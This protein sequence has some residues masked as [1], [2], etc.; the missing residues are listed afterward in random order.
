[1]S[2]RE[3]R[4]RG[5]RRETEEHFLRLLLLPRRRS[6][7][8][9]SSTRGDKC[10]QLPT[11]AI[12][13][14]PFLPV[15]GG[16]GDGGGEEGEGG[17]RVWCGLGPLGARVVGVG[18]RGGAGVGEGRV[19]FAALVDRTGQPQSSQSGTVPLHLLKTGQTPLVYG[20]GGPAADAF[21]SCQPAAGQAVK[22]AG[23]AKAAGRCR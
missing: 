19:C 5:R 11:V 1:M 17:S 9:E 7:A 13:L 21:Q 6:I 23:L 8:L 22:P 12:E 2:A 3:T 10:F 20:L 14:F 15:P 18:G 4:G 16:R